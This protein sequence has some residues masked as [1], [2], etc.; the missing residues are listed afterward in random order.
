MNRF[1]ARTST[2]A[3]IAALAAG[4]LVVACSAAPDE[5]TA[6]ST[7]D[8]YVKCPAY[9]Y[10]D[11][12]ADGPR[13][14]ILCGPC[15]A[16]DDT[17][18]ITDLAGTPSESS[19]PLGASIEV[20]PDPTKYPYPPELYG[21]GCTE[22]A[23]YHKDYEDVAGGRLWY[24]PASQVTTPSAIAPAPAPGFTP[25]IVEGGHIDSAVIGSPKP[26]WV[27]VGEEIFWPC[28]YPCHINHGCSGVCNIT[29]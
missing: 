22:T 6:E 5:K 29:P 15:Y 2:V 18:P 10:R 11:C 23:V 21:M 4:S 17:W 26:G 7:A 13:G 12:S 27:A 25:V 24:C 8:I 3:S 14:Q 28:P 20:A 1:A 9:M 19:N 16:D